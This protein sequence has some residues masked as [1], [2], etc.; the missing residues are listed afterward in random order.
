LKKTFTKI[1]AFILIAIL[2]WGC[3]TEKNIPEGKLLLKTN[4]ISVNGRTITE[5]NLHNQLYQKPNSTI[6][7]YHLR[8]NLYNLANQNPDSTYKAKYIN[9]PE[10]YKRKSKW[11]SAKQIDRLGESFWYHGIHDFLKKTGEQSV[12]IDPT[13]IDKSIL[14]LK[15]YYFNTGYFD[16][17]AQSLIDT[18][19]A[20]KAKLKYTITTGSPYTIDSL[21]TTIYTP[22]LDSLYKI[23]KGNSLLKIGKQYNT[24]DFLEEKN[25]I[26]TQLRNNGVYNF[27]PNNITFDI[28]T[29]NKEGKVSINLIINNYTFQEKDTTKTEPFKI[30][31]ISAV[32]VYTDYSPINR[33]QIITDSTSYNGINLFSNEKL[34]YKPQAITNAIFIAKNFPF[35][36]LKTTLSTRYLNNLKI[37]NY[38]SIQYEVDKKD[39][40][41]HS[42]IAKIY[43]TPRK[44]FSFGYTFDLSHSNIQDF[45]IGASIFE[46][47]RNVFNGAET[48][49]ISARANVGSSKDLANPNDRFFN[50]SEYGLDFKLNIPRILMPFETEKIIPKS[51]IPSTL[52]SI[53][54]A[55]QK[56]IGLDKENLTGTYAYNWNPKKN[57]TSK[58]D[59]FNVQFV[60]NLN[61]ENYF[62]VYGSSYDALN[63][64]AKNPINISDPI[65]FDKKGNLIIES[66]TKGF[67]D[68][69]LSGNTNLKPTDPDYQSTKSIE[70]RRVRLTENDFILATSFSFTKTT[71]KDLL[72]SNFYQFK[73]KIESAGSL[74]SLLSKTANFEK[75]KN[76]NY[77]IFNLEYSEYIKTEF[78]YIKHW[79]LKNQNVLALRSFFGIAI[80]FGNSNYIPFSRSYYSGGSNDNRAW[81]PYS[82]G[83]GT[84]GAVNDFNEANMKIAISSEFRFKILGSVK[85]ALFID[86]GNIWNVLDNV[87]DEKSTFTGIKNL[88]D[89]AIGSGFGIRY[90]LSFFV[91]RFDIGFK[92]YNP[93]NK[94]GEKWFQEY[95]FGHSVLNFGINY[96]F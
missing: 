56:N 8:L 75:N 16:V 21:K 11:L 47:I 32:N 73:T 82:L 28:D 96:P 65:Y 31:K 55:S 67:T 20:K 19:S 13:K 37:F 93:A 69:V 30:Y 68:A 41:E 91:V 34:K 71:K 12:I 27:Q 87:T 35:S 26:T 63:E 44:K 36:D 62:Y 39:P 6:L 72:D 94:K 74:L 3:N 59:L 54:Y 29:I 88:K 49:D 50:V 9:N 46:T 24:S 51:M 33:N 89:I 81:Q 77:Q 2:I 76:G 83:P 45:G 18:I 52:L 48:L 17:K 60:R 7:G 64:I 38:P 4:K 95:N 43:L 61:S 86:A 90:D 57:N 42:L 80:P 25:R 22:E 66:G 1:A 85:G 23:N 5:E 15:S 40:T 70:E 79:D 78:D 14:R 53:G 58:F 10:K 92:T 84:S